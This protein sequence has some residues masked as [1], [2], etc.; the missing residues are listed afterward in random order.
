MLY[1]VCTST[2]H[3]Y[4]LRTLCNIPQ[5]AAELSL[6]GT[7]TAEVDGE[8]HPITITI[9]I[10]PEILTRA[11]VVIGHGIGGVLIPTKWRDSLK[12]SRWCK[13][14]RSVLVT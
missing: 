7:M 10:I 3:K 4:I 8:E 9:I 11:H 1:F 14:R 2:P 5:E 12:A 6:E 13:Q